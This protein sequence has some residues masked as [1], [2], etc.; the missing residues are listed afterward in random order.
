MGHPYASGKKANA[1]CD[2]CGDRCKYIE[3]KPIIRKKV[4]TGLLACP[5]CWDEDHPQNNLNTRPVYDP[6]ALRDPRPDNSLNEDNTYGSRGIQW[7]WAPVGLADP[8]GL[9]NNDL[10]GQSQV[11]QVSITTTQG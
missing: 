4:K 1:I 9:M 8:F 3:L 5:T 7:G 11:G 10:L 2:I 6:Q